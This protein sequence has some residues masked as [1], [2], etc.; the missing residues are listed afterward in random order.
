MNRYS[1]LF[2][3]ILVIIIKSEKIQ[4]DIM[5]SGV[6]TLVTN[7]GLRF[8]RLRKETMRSGM[9]AGFIDH[10]KKRCAGVS[11]LNSTVQ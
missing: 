1:L 3:T 11:G 7:V 5:F 6:D 10:G 9:F 8:E 2:F 4:A